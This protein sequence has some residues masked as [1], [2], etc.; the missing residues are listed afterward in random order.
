MEES[1]NAKTTCIN[2]GTVFTGDFCHNCGQ[3][4]QVKRL[5]L[6]AFWDDY[7]GRI[8]G[9]DTK[10]LRTIKFLTIRPGEVGRSFISGNRVKY[11]GPVGYYF[12][13]TTLFFIITT[14]LGLEVKEVLFASGQSYVAPPESEQQQAF[15][16][17][18][19][20]LISRNFKI[21]SGAIVVFQAFWGRIF[22]R[23]AKLNFLEHA[24]NAFYVQGHLF[25]LTI[26]S[27]IIYRLS[28]II[29]QSYLIIP[30]IVY[31]CWASLQ[32]YQ[33]QNKVKG[34]IKVFLFYLVSFISFMIAIA[35]SSFTWVLISHVGKNPA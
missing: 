13:I 27:T 19:F 15:V 26:M 29:I 5:S 14:L 28:G 25:F 35:L 33:I 23:K 10:F 34:T 30:T 3:K 7:L 18:Y 6:R 24:A 31:F 1:V 9:F 11:I 32:F 8:F 12:L 17:D 16:N 4:R 2:C 21:F 22:F 20:E